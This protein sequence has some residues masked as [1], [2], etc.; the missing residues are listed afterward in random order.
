MKSLNEL[1]VFVFIHYVRL[2]MV[3][4]IFDRFYELFI[5]SST[6]RPQQKVA[7]LLIIIYTYLLL[8]LS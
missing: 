1:L 6:D 5:Q 4:L 2:F 3:R 8:C 7:M